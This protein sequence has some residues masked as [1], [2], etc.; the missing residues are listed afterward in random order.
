MRSRSSSLP[1]EVPAF[2]DRA[3]G[4][5]DRALASFERAH[6]VEIVDAVETQL[7]QVAD[8]AIAGAAKVGHAGAGDGLDDKRRG[9]GHNKKSLVSSAERP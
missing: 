9:H 4:H 3:A 6:H 5:D 8:S 2:P 1:V 7:D